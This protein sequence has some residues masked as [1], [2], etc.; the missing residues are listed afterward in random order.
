MIIAMKKTR[1][2]SLEYATL[3][4][5]VGIL[6]AGMFSRAASAPGR[7]GDVRDSGALAGVGVEPG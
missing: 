7:G 3:L 1:L 4:G 5:V 2:L 6:L